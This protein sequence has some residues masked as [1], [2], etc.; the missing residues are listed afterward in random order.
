MVDFPIYDFLMI[1]YY[2]VL[3]CGLSGEVCLMSYD[4]KVDN[5]K[6]L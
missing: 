3:I 6:L 2:E 4:E 5:R 1:G